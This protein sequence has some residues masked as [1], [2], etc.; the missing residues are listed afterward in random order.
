MRAWF[1]LLILLAGCSGGSPTRPTPVPS[2]T[3]TPQPQPAP[4]ITVSATLTD[5]VTGRS[6]GT[7]S[8]EVDRL[9]ALLPLSFAGYVTRQAWITSAGPTV[10]LIP[11][12][13]F[14]LTFYRQLVR[15]ALDGRMDPLR[16][17][18]VNPSIY[19]QR[20]GLSDATVASL[21]RAARDVVPALTGGRLSVAS[22]ETGQERRTAQSGWIVVELVNDEAQECGR[23]TIGGGNVWL[24]TA[25]KCHRDGTIIGSV[26]LYTHELGHALG[27]WHVADSAALMNA[28]T[29]NGRPTSQERHH[30][31]IA[32]ARLPGNRDV[33]VDVSGSALVTQGRII[34]D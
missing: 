2:P 7:V 28:V 20:E 22:W 14:D 4:R 27:F 24:N 33:D 23:A 30:A 31:A 11:E 16:R 6:V 18:T 19:L 12:A 32:Y 3:P 34:I 15:G 26:N 13:G 5:T 29:S 10:D 8:H 9:P 25:P 21:E 1:A 17:W